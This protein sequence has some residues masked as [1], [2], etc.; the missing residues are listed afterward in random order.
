M[1]KKTFKKIKNYILAHK[2]IS[3]IIVVIIA[4]A[5][6]WGYS[7]LTNTGG[8]TRYVMA[9]VQRGA[10]IASITGSGQVSASN[11]ID[12]KP[13]ASG[14]V[15]SVGVSNGQDVK[16]G[17][18]IAQLDSR[19]AQKG[20]R[21]AQ[22]NLESSKLSL[23][24]LKQPADNLSIIQAENA[25]AQAQESKQQTEVDLVKS[26]D[27]GFNTISNAFIDLPT[28]M[29]GLQDTLY[30]FNY[31]SGQWNMDYYAGA[32]QNFDSNAAQFRN[33][34]N[35]KYQTA[36]SDYD[37]NFNDYKSA[38]RFSDHATIESLVDETY[39]SSK[40]VAE[41]VKSANNLIQFYKDKTIEHNLKPQSLADTHLSNLNAY[42]GK[43]NTHLLN[44]LSIKNTIKTD[45]NN[46]T[47]AERTIAEKT[48][49]LAKLKAGADKLD[50]ESSQLAV[51]QKQNALLDAREKLADYS[52]RAPFDGTIAAMSVKKA[53][54]VSAAT[55][56]ATLITKQKLAEISLNEVDAAKVKVGQKATLTFDA[57]DGLSI[58]GQVAEIDTIGTVTQGVVTYNIKIGF[59]TQDDRVKPGMS[60]SAAIITDI[61][62]DVLA[63]PNSAV[64]T[65][66]TNH[67]VEMFDQKL[68]Q[69]SSSGSNSQGIP[70]TL[71][72]RQQPVEIG[73]S[74]DTQTEIISGLKEGD[75]I[76]ARTVSA[77]QTTAATAPSL[78]GG[79]G[80]GKATGG[81]G[82]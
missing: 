39:N 2:V 56:V 43:L 81:I 22:A 6:Y 61:K 41:A 31:A 80:G 10:V 34:A 59:D 40:N 71:I 8:E 46:I 7:R 20:V 11:Q 67:Y 50:I 27:D 12:I 75:Q 19:D 4:G 57:V 18:I 17:T 74:S 48:E 76:V 37:K 25:L 14:D 1:L 38:N 33:D 73:L 45:K 3:I 65:Q 16:A 63:V 9:E 54:S 58:A 60:V 44:L 35:T 23:E 64:K 47:D 53:D 72:P 55:A 15:I 79:G 29:A 51:T 5:S 32:V 36:R 52:I 24:K 78:F 42:T 70:S 62:Q 77:T 82:H 26:Y 21:D 28:V 13:K 69:S 68:I 49:S 66:G 30:G